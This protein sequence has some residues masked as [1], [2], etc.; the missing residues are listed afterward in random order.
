MII[1]I[2]T[3]DE[4]V[5][6]EYVYYFNEIINFLSENKKNKIE[7][8]N[9]IIEL[10]I[11]LGKFGQTPKNRRIC[12]YLCSC[13]IRI[14]NN[15]NEQIYNRLLIL[16][17]D[18]DLIVKLQISNEM[19]YIINI[20]HEKLKENMGK[21]ELNDAILLY[22]NYD[23]NQNIQVF[24]II[25][26]IYNLNLL[27]KE[28][29]N[30]LLCKIK[31]I[32]DDK[33]YENKLKHD[34]MSNL[35][36]KIST[37]KDE[38]NDIIK[39]IYDLDILNIYINLFI[40]K[41]KEYQFLSEM[42]ENFKNIYIINENIIEEK[43]LNLIN[44][45]ETI[46]DIIY[47]SENN[48]NSNCE[49]SNNKSENDNIS[50]E[51][52]IEIF[53]NYL[54]EILSCIF[55][56]N[57]FNIISIEKLF[58]NIY[59]INF[60]KE[61]NLYL[62]FNAIL[63]SSLTKIHY[64]S[65]SLIKNITTYYTEEKNKFLNE[66]FIN[67]FDSLI[68]AIPLI[69]YKLF[70]KKDAIYNHIETFLNSILTDN[71]Q[72]GFEVIKNCISIYPYLIKFS[73]NREKYIEFIHNN[74]FLNSS[75]YKRRFFIYYL[76]TCFDILSFKFI[77]TQKIF[78]DFLK[79]I[80]DKADI[81]STDAM[82]LFY[83]YNK[84]F[85]N[86][87]IAT[88][89][90]KVIYKLPKSNDIEK[91]KIIKKLLNN[92]RRFSISQEA[93]ADQI[94]KYSNEIEINNKEV[95]SNTITLL[96]PFNTEKNNINN[97]NNKKIENNII[98]NKHQNSK[99][100]LPKLKKFNSS[101]VLKEH[102]INNKDLHN[103]SLNINKNC[104]YNCKCYEDEE[105]STNFNTLKALN[106]SSKPFVNF[107]EKLGKDVRILKKSTFNRN[108]SVSKHIGDIKNDINSISQRRPNSKKIKLKNNN[109]IY[110]HTKKSSINA[111]NLTKKKNSI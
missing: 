20:F 79:I 13:V 70:N 84:F 101:N 92:N 110:S 108:S 88:S 31:E 75:Y 73:K 39:N 38:Y 5:S 71:I 53:F 3:F 23:I 41:K 63:S 22:L 6:N 57:K 34:I 105:N 72:K 90:T 106:F 32:I 9:D 7:I 8:N 65:F 52:I 40:D 51:N 93:K 111:D 81:I 91:N 99:K 76:K 59:T 36:K 30:K 97:E 62:I 43:K 37:N 11:S 64:L 83:D 15:N 77:I 35:I 80:E 98:T 33:L 42:I 100:T 47:N 58:T 29:L 24:S 68:I 85:Y 103:N 61:K 46:L 69:F 54:D 21:N 78:N 48:N 17:N 1:A 18:S 25:S 49:Y 94:E 19:K 50:Y 27:H 60:L 86:E 109:N 107:R 26:L 12:C 95:K 104:N 67:F 4:N 10:I 102:K 89:V 45:F 96:N 56:D 14:D 44:L 82:K 16:F 74:F 55:N 87:G 2:S 28:L 66:Y